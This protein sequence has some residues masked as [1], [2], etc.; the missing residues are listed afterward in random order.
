MGQLE[1]EVRTP[2][3]CAKKTKS[4]QVSDQK[5]GFNTPVLHTEIGVFF[6]LTPLPVYFQRAFVFDRVPTSPSHLQGEALSGS[7]QGC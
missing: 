7:G 3:S 1:G 5:A 6:P 4:L 2:Q